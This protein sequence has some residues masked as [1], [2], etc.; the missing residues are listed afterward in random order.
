MYLLKLYNDVGHTHLVRTDRYTQ[1]SDV[2]YMLN[3]KT[4][5]IY[6]H[7]YNKG[8]KRGIMAFVEIYRI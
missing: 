7:L 3:K 2:C 1:L 8:G 4:H 5:D 6:N